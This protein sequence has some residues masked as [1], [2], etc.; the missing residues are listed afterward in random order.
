MTADSSETSMTAMARGCGAV[1]LWSVD[2]DSHVQHYSGATVA[3][4]VACDPKYLSSSTT[5]SLSLHFHIHSALLHAHYQSK[6]CKQTLVTWVC[7]NLV[8]H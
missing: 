6:S 1:G 2:F 3:C 7:I 8:V 4:D 5:L